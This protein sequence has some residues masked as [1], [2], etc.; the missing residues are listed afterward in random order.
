ME[1]QWVALDHAKLCFSGAR[2]L[3][4][5]HFNEFEQYY[6]TLV[7]AGT[8]YRFEQVCDAFKS[9]PVDQ[10]RAFGAKVRPL[11]TKLEAGSL[12]FI[13]AGWICVEMSLNKTP[14]RGARWL[15]APDETCE[16]YEALKKVL[17]P[18]ERSNAKAGTSAYMILKLID[19]AQLGAP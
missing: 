11:A 15:L 5:A 3:L 13:P 2:I 14:C 12:M 9:V 19:A 10:Q 1:Q 17:L 4:L 6:K 16:A 18:G 7:A 8:P